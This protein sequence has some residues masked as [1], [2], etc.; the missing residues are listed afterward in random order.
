MKYK[1]EHITEYAYEESVELCYNEAWLKPKNLYNQRCLW[2]K[3]DITPSPNE[4]QEY[5]DFFGN[6]VVYFDLHRSHTTFIIKST[7]MVERFCTHDWEEKLRYKIR[8]NYQD[9][10]EKLQSNEPE[11]LDAIQYTLHSPLASYLQPI[12]EYASF[13]FIEDRSLFFSVTDLMQRIHRDFK[14]VEGFTTI[15][16]PLSEVFE[17]KKGV[18]QD[19]AHVMIAC[20]RS[21]GLPARYISGYIETL[22]P[23]GKKRL[24]GADASHAWVS[25]Y[26]PDFG[27]VDFDPTN[28]QIVKNQHIVV[29]WGRDY[30][31][32]APVKGVVITGGGNDLKV[33]VDVEPQEES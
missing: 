21:Q 20:L 7:S 24:T 19:F 27:W 13:S 5:E 26:F 2:Y 11:I 17:N 29:A 15:S 6:D 8:L 32:V 18:C 33:S 16:T 1:I 3:I 22:P 4:I 23:P 31:D 9:S 14:F 28:N 12:K 25:V 10:L 30:S